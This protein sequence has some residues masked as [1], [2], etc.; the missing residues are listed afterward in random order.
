MA[1][2]LAEI[3]ARLAAQDNRKDT[4][5]QSSDNVIY[6]HWNIDEGATARVRYLQDGD[7]SNPFFWVE[8]AMIKL[9][10]AGILG[11]PDSKP[12][13]VQVP[14][15]EMYGKDTP[16]PILAEVR[17]WFK[18]TSMEEMGRKYWKK[19][20]YLF[21]GFVR[22]NPLATDKPPENIIRRFVISPQIFTLVKAA[23][24]DPELENLPTDYENGLDFSICKTSKGGYA[25]YNTSKWSRKES[26]LT[27]AEMAAIEEFGLFNLSEFLPKKPTATELAII[28]EMFE[29]SVNGEAY[30]TARWGAY[31]KPPGVH[32]D[33]D[34]TAQP[35]REQA[36][37]PAQTP[38]ATPTAPVT[39]SVD[40]SAPWDDGEAAEPVTAPAPAVSSSQRANDI[41]AQIRNRQ[42]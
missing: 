27:S 28:K 4:N 17:T 22:E 12:C 11:Q 3:R 34:N 18:D 15:M 26:A 20:S 8:R 31:Y 25:D 33:R 14:C 41:L 2:T 39:T 23:L 21:Q 30:D 5:N 40:R 16:C 36:S 24:L 29:A 32:V 42:K 35:V 38:R 37:R 13:V 6:A 9:P 19:R 7:S 1:S 10:F